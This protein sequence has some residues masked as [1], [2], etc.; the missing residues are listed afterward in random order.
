MTLQL[1]FLLDA[2]SNERVTFEIMA[3]VE[4]KPLKPSG[5]LRKKPYIQLVKK[6]PKLDKKMR[7]EDHVE[8]LL[9]K[10]LLNSMKKQG[11][12]PII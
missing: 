10:N 6:P 1:P 3:L 5:K 11:E 8:I 4:K 2:S 9:M 12:K 7:K